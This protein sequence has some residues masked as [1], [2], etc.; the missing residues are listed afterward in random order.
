MG[1]EE[2]VREALGGR[3]R[4]G[5]PM[6][7]RDDGQDKRTQSRSRFS[8]PADP[9]LALASGCVCCVLLRG[10]G[11]CF[12]C[13]CPLRRLGVSSRTERARCHCPLMAQSRVAQDPSP[14][15]PFC[16]EFYLRPRPLD[17][18]SPSKPLLQTVNCCPV[19]AGLPVVITVT[20][21]AHS[22]R[23]LPACALPSLHSGSRADAA[24][25]C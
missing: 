6:G 12:G 5:R 11:W 8:E 19:V 15:V 17:W 21:V 10:L 25:R 4:I 24:A 13:V 7:W 9:G 23:S 2:G 1:E 14:P 20:A 18:P 3:K 22:H 16:I